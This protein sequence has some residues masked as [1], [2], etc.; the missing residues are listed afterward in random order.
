MRSMIS[1]GVVPVGG[2]GS[3]GPKPS[4]AAFCAALG[5]ASARSRAALTAVRDDD[6]MDF[7]GTHSHAPKLGDYRIDVVFAGKVLVVG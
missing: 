1:A 4:A 3:R 5:S 2:V 7:T 6:E